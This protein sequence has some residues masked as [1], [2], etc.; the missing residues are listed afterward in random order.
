MSR[1]AAWAAVMG[2]PD[3][4]FL[5]RTSTRH[6]SYSLSVK[7]LGKC[8]HLKVLVDEA[9]KC[10]FTKPCKYA[11]IAAFVEEFQA[12]P[13]STHNAEIETKLAYPYKTAAPA[14]VGANTTQ[15]VPTAADS[16]YAPMWWRNDGR[17][18]HLRRR[19]KD[20]ASI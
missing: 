20:V 2:H 19:R 3:G 6:D 11:T 5:L 15:L 10:G 13:L 9:G 18:L 1:D 7:H 16:L 8:I 17:V 12:V 14:P 4:T